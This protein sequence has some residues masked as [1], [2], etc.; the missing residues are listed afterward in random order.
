MEN[1]NYISKGTKRQRVGRSGRRGDEPRKNSSKP[2]QI[3]TSPSMTRT[4]RFSSTSATKQTIGCVDLCGIAGAVCSVA[5]TTL[6][7]S[8]VG[9]KVHKV[10]IWTPPASQGASATCQ[11]QWFSKDGDLVQEASDT[12]MSTSIPAHIVSKPPTGSQAW[13][14]LGAAGNTLVMDITAPVGSIIDVHCTH[15]FLDG[16]IGSPYTVAAGALGV[17]YYLPLDGASDVFLPVSLV[18]TT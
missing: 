1:R 4:W 11:I 14:Q 7:I 16:V 3:P 17:L 6:Q 5:N 2:P 10:S 9:V 12:S 8:S 15:V 18:T 13:F